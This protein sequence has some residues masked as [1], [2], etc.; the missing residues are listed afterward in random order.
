MLRAARTKSRKWLQQ[1]HFR[2]SP[3]ASPRGG[4]GAGGGGG[5]GRAPAPAAGRAGAVRS[6][7][8]GCVG[9]HPRPSAGDGPERGAGRLP[10][11]PR[12]PRRWGSAVGA[13]DGQSPAGIRRSRCC[14]A[15]GCSLSAPPGAV[16]PLRFTYRVLDSLLCSVLVKPELEGT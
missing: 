1:V 13:P 9:P 4:G 15:S 2:G 6:S 14:G 12:E 3:P 11:P 16:P 10:H 7:S 8:G 5:G